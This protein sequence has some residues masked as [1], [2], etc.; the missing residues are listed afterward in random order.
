MAGSGFQYRRSWLEPLSP[1]MW[2]PNCIRKLECTRTLKHIKM[3][4]KL[5][6]FGLFLVSDRFTGNLGILSCFSF[7]V[8]EELPSHLKF[9]TRTME[10]ALQNQTSRCQ[11]V[12]VTTI[13]CKFQSKTNIN[14]KVQFIEQQQDQIQITDTSMFIS[15]S[16]L[17]HVKGYGRWTWVKD[18]S[19]EIECRNMWRD[20]KCPTCENLTRSDG[21]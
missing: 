18:V 6:P 21:K 17:K 20:N 3:V 2:Y 10:Q 9:R 5:S 19:L 15:T 14:H 7:F 8:L 16:M 4:T 1:K 11:K 12:V 13:I